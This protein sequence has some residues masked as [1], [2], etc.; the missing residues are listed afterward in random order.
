MSPRESRAA[1]LRSTPTWPGAL[2]GP[3]FFLLAAWFV[4]GPH[5][6]E[7]PG[8]PPAPLDP[9]RISIEPRREILSDPPRIEIGGVER[10]CMDC[11]R[12]FEPSEDPPAAPA[13]HKNIHLDHGINDQC[14]NCHAI[15]ERN[16]LVLHD[17]SL[18]H[19]SQS[20]RLCA[21]CHGPTYRDW[22]RGAH[23]RT[24][25][26]WDAE[27]G[28][29]RRLKCSQCHDPHHPRSPAMD[30]IVPLPG[31]RVPHG[32]SVEPASTHGEDPLNPRS[33]R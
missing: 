7:L 5:G 14:R 28:E 26:Y 33:H 27:R 23:G 8:S 30:P 4:W 10:M 20:E 6:R 24:N 19:Y 31:P 17:G 11:H 15:E 32:A 9:A 29:V 16:E 13:M 22:L 12:L 3:V 1:R 2:V 21:K 25:G 18:V